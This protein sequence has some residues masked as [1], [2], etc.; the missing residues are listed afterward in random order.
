VTAKRRELDR[1]ATE[2][3]AKQVELDK[4][5]EEF[6]ALHEERKELI[7]H[8]EE[9]LASITARDNDI[10][11][12][13]ARHL[14]LRQAMT[15]KRERIAEISSRLSNLEKENREMD[16]RQES[17]ARARGEA[18]DRVV[19]WT[20]RVNT[21]RDEVETLKGELVGTSHELSTRRAQ[22]AQWEEEIV[23]RQ[24][25][26]EA[27]KAA[28]EEIKARRVATLAATASVE[29]A[30]QKKDAWLKKE[31]VRVEKMEK[32]VAGMREAV[33][34]GK[35][36]LAKLNTEVDV[37]KGEVKGA[38][39]VVKNLRERLAELDAVVARQA[40]HSYSAD[41]AI[42]QMERKVSLPPSTCVHG[43][44]GYLRRVSHYCHT[45]LPDT[46]SLCAHTFTHV[47]RTCI[48]GSIRRRKGS[49]HGPH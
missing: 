32:E 47:A 16:V 18:R 4:C 38:E 21:S 23:K 8:L 49:P 43:P 31:A 20:A 9:S 25:A 29:E 22:N 48:W 13:G 7:L 6:R 37:T 35:V 26:V 39:K 44:I 28:A 19:T 10:A 5:A 27:A 46:H 34:S 36:T 11:A 24:A 3:S 15:A 1:E 2:T 12:Q 41:F 42:A 17:V 40:E 30:V 33:T 14:A 45:T